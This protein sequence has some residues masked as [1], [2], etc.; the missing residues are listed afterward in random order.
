MRQAQGLDRGRRGLDTEP[1]IKFLDQKG[2]NTKMGTQT[3]QDA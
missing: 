2:L 3:L 1:V